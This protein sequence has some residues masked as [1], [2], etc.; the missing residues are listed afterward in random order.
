MSQDEFAIIK[1]F[2]ATMSEMTEGVVQGP[3]DDCAILRVPEGTELCVSTDTLI[4]GVH[5]PELAPPAMVAQRTFAANMSDLAAMGATPHS[6]V[7]AMTL[8]HVD[9]DWLGRFSKVLGDCASEYGIPLVG[10]NLSRGPLSLTMTVNGVVPAG[11]AIRRSG[12]KVGDEIYVSGCVGDAGAG[13]EMLEENPDSKCYLVDRYANPTPRIE[14][15]IALRGVATAMIDVSDGL[16]AD[17]MHLLH[18]SAVGAEIEISRVPLSADLQKR[19]SHVSSALN[20]GDDYE[21]CFTTSADR[22]TIEE[23][24]QETG[25]ALSRIGEVIKGTGLQ[26]YDQGQPLVIDKEG[27]RHFQ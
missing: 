17:L 20:A 22:Q 23:I 4:A 18:A 2:F 7:L 19:I 13:L 24:A 6:F 5:F 10:G 3:G 21:L 1:R 14:L 11:Q 15:G 26:A 27:Y 9:E 8:P 25:V 12:A 16:L